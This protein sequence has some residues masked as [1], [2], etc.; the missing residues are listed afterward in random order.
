MRFMNDELISLNKVVFPW[1]KGNG[2]DPDAPDDVRRKYD[3]IKEIMQKARENEID[4]ILS[5]D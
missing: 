2:L 4:S 5:E 3:R 1:I